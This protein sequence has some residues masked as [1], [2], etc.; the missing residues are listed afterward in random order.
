MRNF[1]LLFF[2]HHH[3]SHFA[4]PLGVLKERKFNKRQQA[5]HYDTQK[6]LTISIYFFLSSSSTSMR[7]TKIQLAVQVPF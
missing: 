7:E 3:S 2:H 5:L 1:Q 4:V 6:S